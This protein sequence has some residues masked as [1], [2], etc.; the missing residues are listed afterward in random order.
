MFL[1]LSQLSVVAVLFDHW[2]TLHIFLLSFVTHFRVGGKG[3]CFILS[4]EVLVLS[5]FHVLG[6][7]CWNLPVV[8]LSISHDSQILLWIMGR[9]LGKREFQASPPVLDLCF[10]LVE[11]PRP[12]QHSCPLLGT[13]GFYFYPLSHIFGGCSAGGFPTSFPKADEFSFHCSNRS[14][15][16]F[17]GFWR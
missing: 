15:T 6:L 4:A 9:F 8:A 13:G 14:S 1:V 17:H 2:R 7:W 12:C 16:S 5:I 11:K 10:V 3:G